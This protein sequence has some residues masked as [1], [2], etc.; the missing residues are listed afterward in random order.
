MK[1]FF[2]ICTVL[3]VASLVAKIA[4]VFGYVKQ[5]KMIEECPEAD[6]LGKVFGVFENLG[7]LL[8]GLAALVVFDEVVVLVMLVVTVL[9]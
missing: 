5:N 6:N 9:F 3:L 2:S 7:T 8:G 4:V 1:M